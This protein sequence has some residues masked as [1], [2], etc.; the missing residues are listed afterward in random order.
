MPDKV[1]DTERRELVAALRRLEEARPDKIGLAGD[2]VNTEL[3]VAGDV[4]A[5]GT[6][7]TATGMTTILG[8]STL[9]GDFAG[10]FVA[11]TPDGWV[12][13]ARLPGSAL[14]Y[15]ATCMIRNGESADQTRPT[16][17]QRLK[18][19]L[20]R[21]NEDDLAVAEDVPIQQFEI[22]Y[23][24]AYYVF[25]AALRKSVEGC[26]I[27]PERAER[28]MSA[29]TSGDLPVQEAMN[30]LGPGTVEE[31]KDEKGEKRFGQWLTLDTYRN[32]LDQA[33]NSEADVNLEKLE[34]YLQEHVPRVWLLGK[35]GAGKSSLVAEI[36]GQSSVEIGN[37]FEPCTGGLTRYQ[38][39]AE[40]PIIEFLDTRGLDETGYVADADVVE[41]S[42]QAHAI[43]VVMKV[44]DP[45]QSSVM[46]V[47][48]RLD[49]ASRKHL[50]AVYTASHAGLDPAEAE[51]AVAH[52]HTALT[53][54]MKQ[55]VPHVFVDFP[56]RANVD[57]LRELLAELMPSAEIF[58]RQTVVATHEE[59]I[60]LA[61][62]TRILWHA[63]AAASAD[64]VPGVGLIA[65][66]SIQLKMLYQ[67]AEAYGLTWGK[68]EVMEFLG[69]LGAGFTLAYGTRALVTQLGR[70]IPV[71]GQTVGQATAVSLSFGLTFALGRGA[72]YYMYQKRN[73][74]E[75]DRE[76]LK[77]V[78]ERALRRENLGVE[79]N[80]AK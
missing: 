80:E 4:A 65:V 45:E 38:F 9:A 7:A 43:I 25:V 32:L 40:Q 51:R 53:Q 12:I 77:Q 3:G 64:F 23:K 6:T 73:G 10:V 47:L 19:R 35:T 72:C 71:W 50:I 66:P 15:G 52:L 36:T 41:A 34:D 68:Q 78:Y 79:T 27:D 59:Q 49:K 22:Q 76:E 18:A 16:L 61:Q 75:V 31:D 21:G 30:L 26:D 56:S 17:L 37:G 54:K 70:L 28:L 13:G 63:G 42:S 60:Y 14:A 2:L 55:P 5:S 62:R 69:S 46:D 1:V 24:D 58:L 48:T 11:T 33:I 29:V 20:G 39:P 8:S 67:L 57:K 44:D 74:A